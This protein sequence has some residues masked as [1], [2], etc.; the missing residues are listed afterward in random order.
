LTWFSP[1]CRAL[2]VLSRLGKHI[3]AINLA[4][5]ERRE[6]K[7]EDEGWETESWISSSNFCALCALSRLGKH[8]AAINLAAKERRERKDEYG[9]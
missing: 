9:I 7:D 6:R 1:A 5:K 4:A 2:C 3:A 8:I